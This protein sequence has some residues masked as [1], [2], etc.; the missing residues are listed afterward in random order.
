MMSN[1]D[2]ELLWFGIG[3]LL[4]VSIGMLF[5]SCGIVEKM[6]DKLGLPDDNILEEAVEFMLEKETGI[7]V[8]FTPR[9]IETV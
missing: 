5:C 3:M 8:D 2:K 7:D 1:F 9:S 4:I 6:N